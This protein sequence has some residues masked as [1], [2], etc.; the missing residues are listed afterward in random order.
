MTEET[1]VQAAEAPAIRRAVLPS[2]IDAAGNVTIWDHGPLEPEG[3]H[4]TPEWRAWDAETRAWRARH[5]FDDD[6]EIHPVPMTMHVSE[7]GQAMQADPRYAMEPALDEGEID[8]EVEA[9]RKTREDAAKV[10]A[11]HADALQ[12]QVDRKAAV[13][14]VIARHRAAASVARNKAASE[15]RRGPAE[16]PIESVKRAQDD[17]AFSAEMERR[18]NYHR[19]HPGVPIDSQEIARRDEWDRANG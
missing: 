2:D 9:I 10:A 11:E 5:G 4:D 17:R 7:A 12:L 14:T 1:E 19:E 8:A 16:H 3:D 18:A 13:V 15:R 6:A